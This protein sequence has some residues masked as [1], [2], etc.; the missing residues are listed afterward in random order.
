M[1]HL[2][3]NHYKLIKILK[4]SAIALAVILV[5]WLV[6]QVGIEEIRS[7]V[8][9][10]GI[11]GFMLVGGLRLTS[12]VIPALPGTAY[13]ALAGGLFG[14]I[15]GL[16]V[17]C[18][19]DLISCNLSFYISRRHGRNFIT[20]LVGDRLMDQIDRFSQKNLENNF[21]L[22]TGLLMT[23]LFDFVAYGVGLTKTS[24]GKFAPALIISIAL[25]NPPIV[26]LGAGLLE[27]GKLLLGFALLGVFALGILTAILQ[28]Q[29]KI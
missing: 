19:A 1:N 27:S 4:Y 23:G 29:Q 25:S 7:N 5:I 9:Q 8:E 18:V 3:H 2:K 15:P 12:V 11:W 24:W 16:I 26:A 22:M 13:S 28:R 20:K 10:L 17:I 6:N 21:W 14:F